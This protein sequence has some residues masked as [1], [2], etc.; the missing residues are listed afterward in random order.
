MRTCCF[1][2]SGGLLGPTFTW[3]IAEQFRLL[4]DGDRHFFTNTRGPEARGLPTGLQVYADCAYYDIFFY[5]PNLE[6]T[7]ISLSDLA[8]PSLQQLSPMFPKP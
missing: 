6:L 7:N 2:S 8:S 1:F 3:M 4:K 5:L